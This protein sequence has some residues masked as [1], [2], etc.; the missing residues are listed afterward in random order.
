[1]D[2]SKRRSIYSS[3]MNVYAKIIS[4]VACDIYDSCIEDYYGGYVP[5]YYKRHGNI[6]GENLY[7]AN[8]IQYSNLRLSIN[9]DE[10][11][12][13]PYG[14]KTDKRESVLGS[15]L[16]GLRGNTAIEGWPM[17]FVTSYPN[18]YSTYRIWGSDAHTITGIF[19]DFCENV[20]EDTIE[21][22]WQCVERQ[23]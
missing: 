6:E 12:L 14:G 4:S 18:S 16:N 19:D 7:L 15:V 1:M 21:L 11:K 8:N 10:N 22:F 2:K 9:I 5:T 13:K 20:I 17:E 23:M 3:A